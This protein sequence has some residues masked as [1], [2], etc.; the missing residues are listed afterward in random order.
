VR[1]DAFAKLILD[2]ERAPGCKIWLIIQGGDDDVDE[3]SDDLYYC[4]LD[5]KADIIPKERVGLLIHSGGGKII[6]AYQICPPV[7]AANA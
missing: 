5:Q 3:I 4:F 6:P 2:L 1:R 7:S